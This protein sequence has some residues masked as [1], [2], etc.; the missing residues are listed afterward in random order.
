MLCMRAAYPL[1]H[2]LDK[3]IRVHEVITL[4]TKTDKEAPMIKRARYTRN[5]APPSPLESSHIDAIPANADE[6]QNSPPP[7]LLNIAQ[8][9][10]MYENHLVRESDIR[11]DAESYHSPPPLPPMRLVYDVN[12]SWAPGRVAITSYHELRIL[13]DIWVAP[14][15]GLPVALP[16]D[17]MQ[18][19]V[20]DT[21]PW[22]FDVVTY[23]WKPRRNR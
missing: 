8:R 17:P 7:D 10:K 9:E 12:P 16:P 23:T 18:P 6:S 21:A 11:Y 1:L 15:P 14:G 5:V 13:P 2:S 20:E 22:V 3:T 4:D 19:T